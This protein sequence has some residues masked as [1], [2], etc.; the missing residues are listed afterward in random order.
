[1]VGTYNLGSWDGQWGNGRF[2]LS[3]FLFAFFIFVFTVHRTGIRFHVCAMVKWIVHPSWGIV[4]NPLLDIYIYIYICLLCLDSHCGMDETIYHD[5]TMAHMYDHQS[6]TGSL[7]YPIIFPLYIYIYIYPIIVSRNSSC[8]LYIIPLCYY[9]FP[10]Y[11]LL[12]IF[13]ISLYGGFLKWGY[14]SI[15]HFIF[16]FSINHPAIEIRPFME[17]S[18][19]VMIIAHSISHCLYIPLSLYYCCL[20][21][22]IIHIPLFVYPI[23]A[24][25]VSHYIYIFHCFYIP[26]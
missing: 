13:P 17:T 26:L 11:I 16:G 21:I 19:Y 14:P 1:M 24:V 15:L 5:M 12:F 6:I 9:Y 23:L 20:Y 10:S 4:I 8:R 7:S 22:S 3:F 25:Y 18:H 2:F